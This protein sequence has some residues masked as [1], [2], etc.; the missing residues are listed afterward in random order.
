[1]PSH[2]CAITSFHNQSFSELL[3]MLSNSLASRHSQRA[4]RKALKDLVVL[5]GG[6]PISRMLLFEYR[7]SM[8]GARLSASTINQRLCAIRKLVHEAQEHSIIDPAEAVRITSVPGVPQHGGLL[9]HW[10]TAEETQRLLSVPDR[11]DLIGK[12]NFALLSVLVYC[13]LRREEFAMLDRSEE[14]TSEL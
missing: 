9:G 2:L 7:A 1:M 11:T 13:A 6:R 3:T 8:I 4:Y 14:H 10:L 5:A 12:R